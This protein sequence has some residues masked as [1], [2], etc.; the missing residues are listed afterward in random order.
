MPTVFRLSFLSG[1]VLIKVDATLFLL[2]LIW[3][4]LGFF[5]LTF[6]KKSL[7]VNVTNLVCLGIGKGA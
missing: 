4:V 6:F 7:L 2:L 5:F 3:V 1:N